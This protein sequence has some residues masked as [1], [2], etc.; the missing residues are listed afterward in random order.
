MQH[1]ILRKFWHNNIKRS[2][3]KF[4]TKLSLVKQFNLT[5]PDN[6]LKSS[7]IKKYFTNKIPTIKSERVIDKN[8]KEMPRKNMFPIV[9]NGEYDFYKKDHDKYIAK[10]KFKREVYLIESYYVVAI[11]R[12]SKNKDSIIL[13]CVSTTDLE[14]GELNRKYFHT[15]KYNNTYNELV[16]KGASIIGMLTRFKVNVNRN[17]DKNNY[18]VVDFTAVSGS[19]TQQIISW[20]AKNHNWLDMKPHTNRLVNYQ[21]NFAI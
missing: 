9:V 8:G 16:L 11:S 13:T 20:Y 2:E 3:D 12:P 17:M 15:Y 6:T 1:D 5:Y 4:T 7:E 21:E 10:R 14:N 18:S 19:K